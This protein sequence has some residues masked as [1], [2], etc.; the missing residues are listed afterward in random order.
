MIPALWEISWSNHLGEHHHIVGVSIPRPNAAKVGASV[1]GVKI[2]SFPTTVSIFVPVKQ[3]TCFANP[4]RLLLGVGSSFGFGVQKTFVSDFVSVLVGIKLVWLFNASQVSSFFRNH[5]RWRFYLQCSD[6]FSFRF[7]L[8]VLKGGFLVRSARHT[9]AARH[10]ETQR[11][12]DR[13]RSYVVR[14]NVVFVK[15]YT[16][17]RV[18][19]D[20]PFQSATTLVLLPPCAVIYAR[21]HRHHSPPESKEGTLI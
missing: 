21:R 20:H 16:V 19:R 10:V 18:C 6:C 4:L 12:E 14:S 9:P 2:P 11:N 7:S 15:H 17:V 13:E 1:F 3:T 8:L 5:F